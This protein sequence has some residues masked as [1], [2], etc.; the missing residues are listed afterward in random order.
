MAGSRVDPGAQV[1]DW[2]V[3]GDAGFVKDALARYRETL[4]MTHLVA[5]R[6]RIG[7]V[8]EQRLQASLA[9]VA[10]IGSELGG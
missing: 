4:G 8:P 10:Q 3:V 6:L 5:T 7:G 1:D 2:A 9:T